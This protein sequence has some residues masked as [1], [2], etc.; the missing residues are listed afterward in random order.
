MIKAVIFDMDGLLVDS[1]PISYAIYKSIIKAYN[2]KE[3]TLENYAQNYSGRTG[4]KNMESLIKE[5][6]LPITIEEGFE[7]FVKDE[8]NELKKNIS[9]KK[10]A[11]ELLQYLKEKD[12][13]VALATSSSGDR[14]I[15]ILKQNNI[16]EYFHTFVYGS[17]VEK[18]KPNPDIFIKAKEKLG[19]NEEECLVLEDSEAGVMAAYHAHIK[20]INIPDMKEPSQ[21]CSH[22]M[23]RKY[24][25]LLEV[26]DYIKEYNGD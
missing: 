25:S 22:M 14:A 16:L 17:E 7:Y 4:H 13:E 18:G 26:I 23:E 24:Q 6:N 21:E 12:I 10:G 9:L 19:L 15:N 1:E 2:N 11:K 5:F 3:F 8:A 20:V